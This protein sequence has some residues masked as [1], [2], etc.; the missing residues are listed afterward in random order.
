MIL[1]VAKTTSLLIKR[2]KTNLVDFDLIFFFGSAVSYSQKSEDDDDQ[3]K[4]ELKK[5]QVRSLVLAKCF[6]RSE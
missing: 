2:G 5:E 3:E 6:Y 1:E 4:E